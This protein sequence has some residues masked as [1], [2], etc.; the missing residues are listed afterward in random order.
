MVMNA[1]AQLGN[2]I[3][4]FVPSWE[5]FINVPRIIDKNNDILTE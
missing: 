1:R 2:R 3:R 4:K 5:E